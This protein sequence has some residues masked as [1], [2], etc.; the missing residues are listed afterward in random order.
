MWVM[1]FNTWSEN[2]IGANMLSTEVLVCWTSE[3]LIL[4][5]AMRAKLIFMM[6]KGIHVLLLELEIYWALFES[7]LVVL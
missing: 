5:L 2:V 3:S 6:L 7:S 4:S 1:L